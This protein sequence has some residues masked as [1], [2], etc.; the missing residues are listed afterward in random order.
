MPLVRN[1]RKRVG[2]VH[3]LRELRRSEKLANSRHHRLGVH[4]VVRHGRRHLLVDGHLLLDGALHAH[5]ADAEL[6]FHQLAYRSDTA[7]AEVINVI[8]QT[9]VF[10]QLEQ[11]TDG[12]VKIFRLQRAVVEAGGVGLLE[13]L[14][15]ELQPAHAREVILARIKKHSVE[16]RG[17]GIQSRRI[18]RTQLAVNLNQRFLR[19]LHRVTAQRSA[20][21]R[22]HIVAFGEEDLDLSHARFRNLGKLVGG[23]FRVGLYQNFTGIGVND[24][25]GGECAF[26]IAH[27]DFNFRDLRFLDLFEE[28][29]IHLAARVRNLFSAL[30]DDAVRELHSYQA[31]GFVHARLE[32]PIKLF[33]LQRNAVNGVERLQNIFIGTQAK[34]AQENGSQELA[35]AVDA[36]IKNVLLVVFELHP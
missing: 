33:V 24:V 16:Q 26:Q 12:P 34:S 6:V 5:Q 23:D 4:Q 18:A 17:G 14:D 25:G 36:H 27:V 11:V 32:R 9:D 13:Q 30:V 28:S 8:H 7:V 35:L 22:A 29:R 20:D 31:G 21:H 15:V 1:L 2:L 10:A 3:E 19:R